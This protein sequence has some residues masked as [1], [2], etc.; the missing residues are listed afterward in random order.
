MTISIDGRVHSGKVSVKYGEEFP[1]LYRNREIDHPDYG[2]CLIYITEVGYPEWTNKMT[3]EVPIKYF[4]TEI[5]KP[6]AEYAKNRR[7][8]KSGL[9]MVKG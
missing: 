3:V 2:H 6:N 5:K 7:L 4:I 9:K 8:Q 1:R